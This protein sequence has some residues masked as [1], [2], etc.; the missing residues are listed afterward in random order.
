MLDAAEAGV[1]G[2]GDDMQREVHAAIV[3]FG[4]QFARRGAELPA[5]SRG[6]PVGAP[7]L[8]PEVRPD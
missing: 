5:I 4:L 1:E 8:Q 6:S 3:H 2:E 7:G